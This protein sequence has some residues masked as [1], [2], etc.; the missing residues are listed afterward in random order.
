MNY[1]A[2]ALLGLVAY[3]LVAPLMKVATNAIPS[4]VAVLISNTI[5][6]VAAAAIVLYTDESVTA[7]LTHPKAPY[8]YAGG[9]AW[10]SA[11]S[12]TTARSR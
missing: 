1:L 11:F 6:I 8:A 7:Y 3:T 12:R 4:N 10:Q 9:L 5:L 2:W